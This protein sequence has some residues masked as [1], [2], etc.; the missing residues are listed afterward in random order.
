MKCD[1]ERRMVVLLEEKVKYPS[2]SLG[3]WIAMCWSWKQGPK[4]KTKVEKLTKQNKTEKTEKLKTRSRA[5]FFHQLTTKAQ[6]Y[7]RTAKYAAW[8]LDSYCERKTENS[9]SVFCCVA[10]SIVI[11]EIHFFPFFNLSAVSPTPAVLMTS[12]PQ[13]SA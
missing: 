7:T 3:L 6:L 2:S 9:F 11:T 4:P 12:P 5:D 10:K 13:C 8:E 1:I